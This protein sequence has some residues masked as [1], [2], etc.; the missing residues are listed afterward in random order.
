MNGN[1]K[2]AD[3]AGK[4]P[5]RRSLSGAV[6]SVTKKVAQSAFMRVGAD[7][8]NGGEGVALLL[9]I[10]AEHHSDWPRTLFAVEG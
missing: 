9:K 6:G 7:G 5:P 1:N 2:V 8:F 10:R 3:E 4:A